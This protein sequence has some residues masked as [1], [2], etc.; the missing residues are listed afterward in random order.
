M[1]GGIAQHV[2]SI[3]NE[4]RCAL[5]VEN[6]YTEASGATWDSNSGCWVEFGEYTVES[7]LYRT[8]TCQFQGNFYLSFAV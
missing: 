6:Q 2:K 5:H 1:Q 3:D 8:R 4:D 7:S